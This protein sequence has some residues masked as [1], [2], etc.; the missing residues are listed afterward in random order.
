[1]LGEFFH[2]EIAN[3]ASRIN[4]HEVQPGTNR[5]ALV[6]CQPYERS[7]L[8]R[9]CIVPKPGN[10]LSGSG[11]FKVEAFK[12]ARQA[13]GPSGFAGVQVSSFGG[14]SEERRVS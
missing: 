6:E 12:E 4:S 11:V 8:T 3:F 9:A 10:R 13:G 14:I 5:K 7:H 2:V 1:M